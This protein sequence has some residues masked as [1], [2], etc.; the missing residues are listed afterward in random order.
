MEDYSKAIVYVDSVI[1]NITLPRD[2]QYLGAIGWVYAK[3][4]YNESAQQQI[5]YLLELSNEQFVEP[6]YLLFA[7]SGL[8]E[9]ENAFSCIHKA[10]ELHTGHM[11]YL[12]AYVDLFLKDISSDPRYD[13]ILEKMGFESIA[14]GK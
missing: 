8:G 12:R 14:N 4:G 10:Y 9:Y 11:I 1:S 13:E 5:E 3:A 7:Y 2:F 6:V